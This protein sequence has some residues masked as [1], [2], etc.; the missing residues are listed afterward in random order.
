MKRIFNV[1]TPLLVGPRLSKSQWIFLASSARTIAE[2]IILGSS[3]AFFLPEVFQLKESIQVD[4]YLLI[5]LVGL[6]FLAAGV[7]LYERNTND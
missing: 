4:R 7:I 3:A 2:G 1:I 6:T 5:L